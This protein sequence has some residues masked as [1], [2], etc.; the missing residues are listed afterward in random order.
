[1]PDAPI[2]AGPNP[3]AGD[4]PERKPLRTA[5]TVVVMRDG[6]AGIEVLLLRRAERNDHASGAWVFPGGVLDPADRH[7]HPHCADLDDAR[8]SAALGIAEGG[9]DYYVAAIRECFEEAGLLLAYGSDGRLV[10]HEGERGAELANWRGRLHRGETTMDAFCAHFGL[11]LA[12]DRLAY[13][14]RWVTP[15]ARAKRWDT[16]F[17]FALAPAAQESSHDEVELVEQLWLSPADAVKRSD[18]L[19]LLNPTRIT[20]ELLSGFASVAD[21]MAFARTPRTAALAVPRIAD[22]PDGMLPVGPDHGA[23]AEVGKLDP[24]SLGNQ[25]YVIDHGRPVRLSPRVIR[26]TAANPGVMTGPGTNTYL[27]GGGSR[28]EWAVIDPGPEMPGHLDAV[29][30]AA[31]GPVRWIL[32]T[33]SHPDHS[34]G[35]VELARRT[36]AVVMGRV[37]DHPRASDPVFAPQRVLAHGER[38]AVGDDATLRVFHTPGHAS[39]H[40]CYLLEQERLLFTGDHLMQASTVVINPPDGDM[41][42]YL[43]SL[44]ALLGEDLEWLAPG[45]GFLMANPRKVIEG[46]VAHRLKREAKVADALAAIGPASA[47]DLLPRVYDDVAPG[48]HPVAMRS[49]AA[50]LLK[51]E[52]D[53]RARRDGERWSTT[54]AAG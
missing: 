38:L 4:A 20:L 16:R 40:L 22:G 42:A 5:A 41:A 37:A 15:P 17:F 50:H 21:A 27:V 39:N 26:V 48:L 45:H 34:P 12:T 30:A 52:H 8:A 49:L 47:E 54:N 28:N 23:Y 43:A 29:L 13:Q 19:K 3:G 25:R 51:L 9:L 11:T 10:S 44:R 36:G 31:P 33:H 7:G 53:G 46:I 14:A 2:P 6:P 32:A 35:A 1:M 18:S 24:Q